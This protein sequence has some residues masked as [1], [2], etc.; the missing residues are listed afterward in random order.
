M[1]A[2]AI[3]VL[4]T[5]A[6]CQ[7]TEQEK[8]ASTSKSVKADSVTINM[9]DGIT[10][11]QADAILNTSSKRFVSLLENQQTAAAQAKAASRPGSRAY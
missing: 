3:A 1:A 8:T 6:F 4:A 10:R 5:A 7:Q 9:P 2:A 11:D